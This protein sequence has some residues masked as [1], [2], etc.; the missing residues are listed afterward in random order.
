MSLSC[1]GPISHWDAMRVT[2]AFK[3]DENAGKG[4]E[5]MTAK[6]AGSHEGNRDLS[7]RL[8]TNKRKEQGV[9]GGWRCTV[10]VQWVSKG[11]GRESS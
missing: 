9:R 7:T 8:Y 11:D 5:N 10:N 6:R 4:L 1:D 3:R 2:Q